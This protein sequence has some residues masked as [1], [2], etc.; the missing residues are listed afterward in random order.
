MVFNNGIIIQYGDCANPANTTYKVLNFPISY[1]TKRYSIVAVHLTS[2]TTA[3]DN[4]VMGIKIINNSSFG[5]VVPKVNVV[6]TNFWISVG[7]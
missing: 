6:M 3:L 1:K 7:N 5:M 4:F 2:G